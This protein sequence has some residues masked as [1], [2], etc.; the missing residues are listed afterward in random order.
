MK[1][2]V[3]RAQHVCDRR[4]HGGGCAVDRND[5]S[6]NVKPYLHAISIFMAIFLMGLLICYW[7][8]DE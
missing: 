4:V 8:V 7:S 1:E 5:Q 2:R 6:T 3:G